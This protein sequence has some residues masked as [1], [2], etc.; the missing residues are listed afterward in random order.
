MRIFILLTVLIATLSARDLVPEHWIENVPATNNSIQ[1]SL[2]FQTVAGV[3]AAAGSCQLG[4]VAAP[5]T[6]SPS[7][8]SSA[9]ET[10]SV[11]AVLGSATADVDLR[12]SNGSAQSLS[13]P[14]GIKVMKRRVLRVAVYKVTEDGLGGVNNTPDLIPEEEDLKNYLNSQ[15]FGP[16]L[17]LTLDLDIVDD[18]LLLDWKPSNDEYGYFE[19]GNPDTNSPDQQMTIDAVVDQTTGKLPA[20]IVVFLIGANTMLDRDKVGV[21]NQLARVCWVY[22]DVHDGGAADPDPYTSVE[23][24]KRTIA[25]EIGHILVGYGHP[26]KAENPGPAELPGTNWK[27]RLMVSGLYGGPNAGVQFVK[28]EWDAAEVELKKIQP[29][30]NP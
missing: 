6:F 22:G 17:N 26:D 9:E 5:A 10:V 29:T 7:S 27:A 28:G 21:T 12:F 25:H 14:V 19:V 30:V 3:A 2:V 11:G 13:W 4:M 1:T 24:V 23:K 16:Q 8:L 15:V 18:N 20:D